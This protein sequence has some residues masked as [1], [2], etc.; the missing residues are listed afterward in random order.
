MQWLQ[1]RSQDAKKDSKPNLTES[2]ARRFLQ[3]IVFTASQCV[4]LFA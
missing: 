1:A 2:W 4:E 3:Q